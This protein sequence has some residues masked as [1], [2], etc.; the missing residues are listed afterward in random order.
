M[1]FSPP[2]KGAALFRRKNCIFIPCRMFYLFLR[3][4]HFHLPWLLFSFVLRGAPQGCP[5]CK[6]RLRHCL[7]LRTTINATLITFRN[8][9]LALLFAFW[10]PLAFKR[11]LYAF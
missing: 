9:K 7:T 2:Q 11:A 1:M 8:V 6:Q 4:R 5:N 3:H 10:A